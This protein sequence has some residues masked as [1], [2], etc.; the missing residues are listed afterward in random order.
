[1][2][3]KRPGDGPF[4]T[5]SELMV[6]SDVPVQLAVEDSF[7]EVVKC[8]NLAPLDYRAPLEF[9]VCTIS[10]NRSYV[11]TRVGYAMVMLSL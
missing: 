11:N 4:V 7:V 10:H 6:F 2:S 8:L 3:S 1:M 5:K 9:Q